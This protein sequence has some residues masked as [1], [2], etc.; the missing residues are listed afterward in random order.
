MHISICVELLC[1][2]D[3]DGFGAAGPGEVIERSFSQPSVFSQQVLI[4]PED[5]LLNQGHDL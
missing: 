2:G 3:D 4:L 1:L 5:L